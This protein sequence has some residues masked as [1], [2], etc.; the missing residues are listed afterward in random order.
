MEK[1]GANF[2][3]STGTSDGSHLKDMKLVAFYFGAKYC[4]PSL[5]FNPILTNFY[6]EIN[7]DEKVFEIIYFG[8]D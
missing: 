4:R 5:E 2:I 1:Y 7:K 3:T 8:F 6:K